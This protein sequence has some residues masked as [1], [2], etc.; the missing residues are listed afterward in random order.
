MERD[1]GALLRRS[2]TTTQATAPMSASR[3]GLFVLMAQIAKPAA[4]NHHATG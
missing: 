1:H 4:H 2:D 3:N